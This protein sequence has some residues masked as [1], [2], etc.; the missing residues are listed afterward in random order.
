MRIGPTY[1]DVVV[2]R[3]QNFTGAQ[4]MHAHG[5]IFAAV[6]AERAQPAVAGTETV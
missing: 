2:L 3:W 5:R 4:A 1:V 6:A